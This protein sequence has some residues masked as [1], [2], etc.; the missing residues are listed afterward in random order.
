MGNGS[1]IVVPMDRNRGHSPVEE[2]LL[3]LITGLPGTGKSAVAE[4]VAGSLETAVLSHDWAMSALRPYPAIQGVLDAMEPPG[5]RVVGWSIMNSLAREQLR[6]GRSIV[7]DG[8]ART[9]EVTQCRQTARSED[10]RMALITTYCSDLHIHRA[11][12]EER[13]RFI[14]GWYELDWEHV[15]ES[16]S[17]WESP[18]GADL[19]LDATEPWDHNVFRLKGLFGSFG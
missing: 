12:I 17:A 19:S 15:Q 1:G 16:L 5:H 11:R 2:P 10:A 9:R 18:E 3:V 8:V 13:Q 14:P 6:S 4:V 7:L